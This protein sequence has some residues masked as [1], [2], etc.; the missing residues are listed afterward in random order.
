MLREADGFMV[1]N[2]RINSI[3]KAFRNKV[4][5]ITKEEEGEDEALARAIADGLKGERVSKEQ[6]IEVLRDSDGA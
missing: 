2:A 3:F 5:G 6:I 4:D 1:V